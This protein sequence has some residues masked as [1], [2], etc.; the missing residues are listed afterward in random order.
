MEE[1]KD[2]KQLEEEFLKSIQGGTIDSPAAH[3]PSIAQSA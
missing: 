2:T 3:T 1:T